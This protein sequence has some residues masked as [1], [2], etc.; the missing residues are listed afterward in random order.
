MHG[1]RS[2]GGSL[3]RSL[4][5]SRPRSRGAGPSLR[6]VLEPLAR[7]ASRS[8]ARSLARFAPSLRSPRLVLSI[9]HP[10]TRVIR[11]KHLSSAIS[12][13]PHHIHDHPCFLVIRRHESSAGWSNNPGEAGEL[14]VVRTPPRGCS[15]NPPPGV[16][17]CSEP[18]KTTEKQVPVYRPDHTRFS[19]LQG[20]RIYEI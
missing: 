12:C 20:Y 11:L 3:T 1:V 10:Q 4:A 17:G 14:V 6:S 18:P 5:R 2:R 19:S 8:L 7:S 16:V 13:H 15:N 9:C